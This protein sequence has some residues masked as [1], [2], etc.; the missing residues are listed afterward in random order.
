M[1]LDGVGLGVDDADVNPLA[2][3]WPG[4][5]ALAGRRWTAPSWGAEE[6]GSGVGVAGTVARS[7]DAALDHAGIPQSATGQ[8][9]LLTGLNAA[10]TMGGHYGPWPGPTLRALLDHGTLFHDGVAA[11]GAALANVYPPGYFAALSGRRLRR[12]APVHAALAAGLELA[13]VETYERGEAVSAD[14]DGAFMR[15]GE[16]PRGAP[17]ALATTPFDP[18]GIVGEAERLARL[19]R[20][21]SFTFFDVWLTDQIGHRADA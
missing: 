6:G 4:L 3:P 21:H 18:V 13:T 17:S 15:V 1:F 9:S 11:G 14:L 10:R 12:S 5:E 16:R 19:A 20:R 8:T 7:L 2:A